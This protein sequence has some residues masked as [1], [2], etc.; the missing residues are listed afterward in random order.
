MSISLKVAHGKSEILI[1]RD[2]RNRLIQ[3]A[4]LDRKV[5]VLCDDGIPYEYVET[6]RK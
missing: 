5:L 6:V 4:N 1:E 2:V 3:H